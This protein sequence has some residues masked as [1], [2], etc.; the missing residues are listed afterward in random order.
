MEV[1]VKQLNEYEKELLVTAPWEMVSEEYN[2]LLKRY[3]KLPVNGFR[4]G[5]VSV[6]AVES[7]Y[8]N[9]LKNDLAAQCSTRLCRT[10]LKKG[11]LEAGSPVEVRD[12]QFLKNQPLHLTLRFIEM[13]A[14]DLP[15]YTHLNLQS[16]EEEGKL[17]EISEKLLEQTPISIAPALIENELRYTDPEEEITTE[18]DREA[19]GK[20]VKLMLILKKI[21]TQDAI[22][23][24][25]K[26]VEAR[27]KLIAKENEVTLA[28]LK[29][30]LMENGGMARLTDSLLA[31]QVFQYIISIQE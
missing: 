31:E 17:N 26:D 9:Q 29:E 21:A 6:N 15:D 18:D 3:L 13:P 14:F 7:F 25:E 30:F 8:K 20:R 27:L 19:A 22:E 10:A 12:I 24:D 1:L 4:P 11:G 5:K 28:E 16:K 2:D 23:V